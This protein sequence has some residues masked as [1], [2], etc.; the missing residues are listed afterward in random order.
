[1]IIVLRFAL[2]VIVMAGV[3]WLVTQVVPGVQVNGDSAAP[4]GVYGT[5][6]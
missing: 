3:F 5:F 2:K 1:M 6:L 4:L